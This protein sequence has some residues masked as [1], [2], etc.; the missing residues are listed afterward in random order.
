MTSLV[1]TKENFKQIR[2]EGIGNGFSVINPH[3]GFRKDNRLWFGNCSECGELVTNSSLTGK[4]WEHNLI[5]EQKL[6]EDGSVSYQS[7]RSVGYCPSK[8]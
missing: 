5:L 8:N 1:V 2:E 4:G 3:D 6:R 7:S